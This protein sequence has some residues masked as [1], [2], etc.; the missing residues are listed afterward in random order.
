MGGPSITNLILN[1]SLLSTCYATAVTHLHDG[2]AIEALAVLERRVVPDAPNGYAPA[3]VDCPSTRPR[4]RSA[5][6]LS[7]EETSWL[8]K[9][10]NNTIQPLRDFLT[11]V[12]IP[13]FDA[14]AYIDANRNNASAIPNIGIA[15]SGG[16]YRA[17]MNGA[18]VLSAFDSRT[19]NSTNTGH[20][21]GLLQSATYLA[22]LSG[23]G[24]LVGS[25]SLNNFTSVQDIVN[26]TP[27]QIGSLWQFQNSIFAG[28]KENAVQNISG[29]DYY[30][31]LVAT[32]NSKRDAGYNA[33]LTDLW[34]RALSYQLINSP[35]GGPGITWTGLSDDPTF[36]AANAP[37]PILVADG[38][39]PGE[40]I[41]SL[42]TTVFEFNPWEMGSWDPT[43]YGF[44]PLRY[45][46]SNFSQGVI[47]S[48]QQC[49]RGF[50]N[51]GFVMGTSSSLFNQF[52]LNLD[53]IV[54]EIPKVFVSLVE[55][56][57]QSFSGDENDIA[58]W[59]PNPFFGWNNDSNPGAQSKR[60][61]LVDGGE[62]LQNLPLQPLIQPEREVDVIFAV[63]SSA[64]TLAPGANWPNGTALV[65]TYARSLNAEMN[66]GTGFPAIPDQNTFVNL[67][68]NTRPTFFGCD[69]SNFTGA[70]P[71][72]LVYIPNHP[73]IY[74]S[75]V[76][77]FTFSY[78]ISE[79]NA[80]IENGYLV[81]TRGNSTLDE[82]W[83]QCVGCAIMSRTWSKSGATVPDVC[84]QCFERYCWNGT[85]ASE[86]PAQPYEPDS[87][88]TELDLAK[89]G[90]TAL[91]PSI[92]SLMLAFGTVAALA[93]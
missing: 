4:V 51:A 41:I 6:T 16:G 33:S 67:G 84:N 47:P 77:T 73:F 89:N 29:G 26:S 21:G 13:G 69:A 3:P 12:N 85:L 92:F 66:N 23:G 27:D 50:D 57:L 10:R 31:N 46:G 5:R 56:I 71:P 25:L 60:L 70:P 75:N 81:G 91:A 18:G 59:T 34:G 55:G 37:M 35:Q 44:A 83:P 43:V 19:N 78:N 40:F 38:R 8:E 87:V 20:I 72:L 58:D 1:I 52:I 86:T 14:G 48:N 28:P 11:R 61:T 2:A 45:V 53:S 68:L 49:V 65:A 64:D 88:F 82:Q 32:V 42:N 79:R 36:T 24:W 63:D 30:S 54:S 9:R 93:L 62:D 76:S 7:S 39:A 80:I 22:G 90:G 74:N 17:L 15:C